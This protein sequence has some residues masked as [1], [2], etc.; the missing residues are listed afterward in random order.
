MASNAPTQSDSVNG[1]IA[2]VASFFRVS[3]RTVNEWKSESPPAIAFW[4]YGRNIIFGEEAIVDCYE[5]RY[6]SAR[7]MQPGEIR[8][9]ARKEWREHLKIARA[10]RIA[11]E[12]RELR[13]RVQDLEGSFDVKIELGPIGEPM[14]FN[15]EALA[16]SH[17]EEAE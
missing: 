14:V 9:I 2:E 10:D 12:L 1:T 8:E 17:R 6:M 11:G 7:G 15:N 13:R 5:K 3:E 16:H 4:Q